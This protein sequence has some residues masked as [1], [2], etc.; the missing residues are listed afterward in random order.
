MGFDTIEINLVRVVVVMVSIFVVVIIGFMYNEVNKSFQCKK[1]GDN[2]PGDTCAGRQLS[3]VG[4]WPLPQLDNCPCATTAQVDN[5]IVD[6]M[7][8]LAWSHHDSVR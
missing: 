4:H 1:G 3:H 7:A 2:Y 8:N 6:I 5:I